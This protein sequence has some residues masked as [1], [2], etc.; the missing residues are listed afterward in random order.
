M[1]LD[2]S[3]LSG[4]RVHGFAVCASGQTVVHDRPLGHERLCASDVARSLQEN[5]SHRRSSCGG[6]KIFPLAQVTLK[7]AKESEV[8]SNEFRSEI[9]HLLPICS[10]PVDAVSQVKTILND[11]IAY[12]K[13]YAICES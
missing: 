12:L 9:G 3:R 7:R 2:G 6:P 8:H 10:Q 5:T 1:Q 4:R 11:I 13:N